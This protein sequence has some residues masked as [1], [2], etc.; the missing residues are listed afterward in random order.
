MMNFLILKWDMKIHQKMIFVNK[1]EK[2][3]RISLNTFN[4]VQRL[5]IFVI[6]NDKMVLLKNK[7]ESKL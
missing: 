6:I 3:F 7:E 5:V 4:F 2:V 1:M